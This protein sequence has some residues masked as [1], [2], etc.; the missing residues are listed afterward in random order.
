MLCPTRCSLYPL[1]TTPQD[2]KVPASI[3]A[4]TFL[5]QLLHNTALFILLFLLLL[6]TTLLNTIHINPTDFSDLH[7]PIY[8][9]CHYSYCYNCPTSFL[10]QPV[11]VASTGE[12][13]ELQP[14]AHCAFTVSSD[15]PISR[16]VLSTS[17][18]SCVLKA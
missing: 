1:P 3:V 4:C 2:I 6:H 11:L 10:S 15:G 14:M 18:C 8:R 13:C 9:F 5:Y 12:G 16:G 7:T 17:V